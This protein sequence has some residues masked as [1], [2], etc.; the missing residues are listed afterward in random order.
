M[1]GEVARGEIGE[2]DQKGKTKVYIYKYISLYI[3]H[4]RKGK[5]KSPAWAKKLQRKTRR[6]KKEIKESSKT[7]KPS[8]EKIVPKTV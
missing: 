2:K 1:F 7:T 5:S 8:H 6:E 4:R 3:S